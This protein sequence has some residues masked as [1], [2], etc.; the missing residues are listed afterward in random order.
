[1]LKL[2]KILYYEG[3]LMYFTLI[4]HIG[5]DGRCRSI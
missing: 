2:Y 3:A 4:T 1:M 5:P